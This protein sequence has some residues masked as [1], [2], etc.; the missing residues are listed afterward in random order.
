MNNSIRL[1]SPYKYNGIWV[2]DDEQ[3]GLVREAFVAGADLIIDRLVESIPNASDG[4]N[5][6]FSHT[7]FPGYQIMLEWIEKEQEYGGN[8]YFCEEYDIT[9]WLCP[10]LYLYFETAPPLLYL[11]AVVK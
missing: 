9:G 10:A 7:P 2:F 4:F 3:V 11:M 5:L 1:I 8:I 6:L